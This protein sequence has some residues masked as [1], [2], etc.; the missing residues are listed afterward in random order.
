MSDDSWVSAPLTLASYFCLH[1]F[2]QQKTGSLF[3]LWSNMTGSVTILG[4]IKS[5]RFMNENH[6]MADS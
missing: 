4:W 2:Y 5:H 1:E 6:V 3:V